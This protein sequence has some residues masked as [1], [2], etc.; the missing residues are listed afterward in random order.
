MFKL[1][2]NTA[3]VTGA[4][5]GIGAAIAFAFA[6]AGAFV[7]AAD[8]DE[9][10]AENQASVIRSS[11]YRALAINLDVTNES[12]CVAVAAQLRTSGHLV[13]LLV[14]NAGIGAVG[15]IVTTSGGD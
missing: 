2:N 10:G 3:L 7:V 15:S 14:N 9:A 13:D 6:E 11:G 4:A 8:R 12:Q 5:S 1:T